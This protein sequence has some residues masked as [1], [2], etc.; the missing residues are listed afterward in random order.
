MQAE[1]R[2]LYER[3]G[4]HTR[5]QVGRRNM[6]NWLNEAPVVKPITHIMIFSLATSTVLSTYFL[7]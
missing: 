4:L 1:A 6:Q 7:S 2:R 5:L 3:A